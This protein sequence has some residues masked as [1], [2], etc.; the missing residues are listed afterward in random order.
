MFVYI[1]PAS[2]PLVEAAE[3]ALA[4]GQRAPFPPGMNATRAERAATT[5][6][7]DYT[8]VSRWL[9]GLL[10]TAGAAFASLGV[11]AAV[12]ALAPG[13]AGP[14]IVLELLLGGVAIAAA[15]GIPSVLL[16]WKLHTS[17]RR[18]ARAAGFWAALPYLAGV[19]QPV[20]REFIPVRLPHRSADMLLRLITV[21]LGMLAAVFS[22]SMIFYATLVTPNAAL[23]VTAML[24]S[25]LFVAVTLG[26][27]GGIVRIERGYGY[28]DPSIY[29]R[30]MRR[31]RAAARRVE[32]VGAPG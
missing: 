20:T 12:A 27:C 4:A 6:R 22:V 8:R 11:M 21:S 9:L 23:W 3:E 29:D 13:L 16:L 5:V 26:Q 15:A 17:G 28:R 1:R 31:S 7:A 25:A 19:R 2:L 32:D 18:L 24:W 10:A 30:R 14:V